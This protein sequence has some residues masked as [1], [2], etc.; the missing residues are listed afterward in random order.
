MQFKLD[1]DL[2]NNT[3]PV[4]LASILTR[5]AHLFN[6]ASQAL[7]PFGPYGVDE[8]DTLR[9]VGNWTISAARQPEE[10]TAAELAQ[11]WLETITQH[12]FNSTATEQQRLDFINRNIRAFNTHAA[13]ILN[14]APRNP[15]TVSPAGRE[16]QMNDGLMDN[17]WI[18]LADNLQAKGYSAHAEA[19]HTHQPPYIWVELP[20]GQIAIY[21]NQ[22]ETWSADIYGSQRDFENGIGPF[23][24]IDTHTPDNAQNIE[25]I[26]NDFHTYLQQWAA[27]YG[28][29]SHPLFVAP[30]TPTTQPNPIEHDTHPH[31]L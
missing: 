24:V 6:T 28:D 18:E 27:E 1:I 23:A 14:R 17:A 12:N 20:S 3:S 15:K 7:E 8:P 11:K 16:E 9:T 2:K 25:L 19:I 22:N 30:M 31:N 10:M 29:P 26:A 5:L 21:S 4:Y 13:P